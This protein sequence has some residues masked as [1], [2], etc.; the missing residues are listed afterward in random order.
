M[1]KRKS[2]RS[3]IGGKLSM[4]FALSMN[5][6]QAAQSL[7][8]LK[9]QSILFAMNHSGLL[10]KLLKIEHRFG[11]GAAEAKSMRNPAQNQENDDGRTYFPA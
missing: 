9:R 6:F 10:T 7:S 3:A 1:E 5:S 2:P 8:I 11:L 4:L